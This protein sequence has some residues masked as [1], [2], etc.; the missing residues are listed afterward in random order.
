MG[1]MMDILNEILAFMRAGFNEVNAVQGLLIALVAALL[2]PDLRRL[3][4]FVV[5]ATLIHLLV[6]EIAPVIANGAAFS[7]PPILHMS[8]WRYV[9][10]LV[11]GYLIVIAVFAL[12]KRV[13]LRR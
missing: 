13:L 5:G 3:P 2:L 4:M 7:L 10:V 8:Y 11:V 9:A 12:I 6:D 1:D